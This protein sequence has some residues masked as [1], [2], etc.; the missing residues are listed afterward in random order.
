MMKVEIAVVIVSHRI[1]GV[2]KTTNTIQYQPTGKIDMEPH[3][4]SGGVQW[5]MMAL[6]RPVE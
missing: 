1:F 2:P 5:Q 4:T 6:A 3:F